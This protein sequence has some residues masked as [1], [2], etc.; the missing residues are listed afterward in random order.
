MFWHKLAGQGIFMPTLRITAKWT[1]HP[2]QRHKICEEDFGGNLY[3]YK[4]YYQVKEP[5]RI[6]MSR[7][8]LLDEKGT[9]APVARSIP[10]KPLMKILIIGALNYNPERFCAWEEAGCRTVWLLVSCAFNGS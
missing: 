1:N 9:Y 10:G 2:W 8:R 7:Y 5:I 3:K 4:D 6:R